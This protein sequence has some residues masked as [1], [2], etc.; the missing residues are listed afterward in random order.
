MVNSVLPA[1]DPDAAKRHGQ[2]TLLSLFSHHS[3]TWS[4]LVCL[5]NIFTASTCAI[6]DHSS[7]TIEC[8]G[9]DK[10]VES[11]RRRQKV[12]EGLGVK[13]ESDG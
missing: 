3:Q 8:Q 1:R 10:G 4:H 11:R 7:M 9:F 2:K 12:H 5:P 6:S 13:G